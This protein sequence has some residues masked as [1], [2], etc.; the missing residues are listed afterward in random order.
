MIKR[1]AIFIVFLTFIISCK[2]SKIENATI[3]SLS[4]RSII[5]N[6]EG[7]RF[8]KKILYANLLIKYDGKTNLPNLNASL[9][10]L[11]DSVIWISF[12]KLG[13]P[14]AKLMITPTKVK[15]YEKI[16]KT[17]FDGDFELISNWLGTEFDFVKIQNLFYGETLIDMK[18]DKYKASIDQNLYKLDSKNKTANFDV[19]FWISPNTFKLK[20]Q[21]F[22]HPLKEE[23]LTVLY[24]DFNKID[25]SLFPKGFVI[26]VIDK[27]KKTTIDVTYKSVIFNTQQNFPFEMP[28]AYKNI[29]L[30]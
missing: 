21:E 8:D 18:L 6:N 9:R 4:A 23:I 10:M 19:L 30:K 25:E 16:T 22:K 11:K 14:V 29:E 15:F 24:K 1:G 28:Q 13:F 27:S 5:K 17:Y 12:S 2:S 26:Q 3:A 7:I 20:K